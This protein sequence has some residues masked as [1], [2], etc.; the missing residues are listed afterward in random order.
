LTVKKI[1]NMAKLYSYYVTNAR[2]ELNYT[3]H[4]LND[5][6]FE[7]IMQNYVATIISNDNMFDEDLESEKENTNLEDSDIINLTNIDDKNLD[8]RNTINLDYALYEDDSNIAAN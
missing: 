2:E 3:E 1:S 8:I 4:K 6:E 5:N 7:Q